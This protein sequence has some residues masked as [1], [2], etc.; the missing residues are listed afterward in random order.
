MTDKAEDPRIRRARLAGLEHVTKDA[1]VAE[2]AADGT[3][4]NVH[5]P[6]G[7]AMDDGCYAKKAEADEQRA[8]NDL[9]AL[10]RH[11]EKQHRPCGQNE[12]RDSHRPTLDDHM[13]I[14][15]YG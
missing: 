3:M 2:M 7:Y 11:A 10:R 15:S 14:R 1:T 6:D 12:S 5:E 9:H 4:T 8:R 13:A